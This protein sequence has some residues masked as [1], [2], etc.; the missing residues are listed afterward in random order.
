VPNDVSTP[1]ATGWNMKDCAA[2]HRRA[3]RASVMEWLFVWD[4]DVHHSMFSFDLPLL[5]VEG[6]ASGFSYASMAAWVLV[7]GSGSRRSLRKC[8]TGSDENHFVQNTISADAL[9]SKHKR[10]FD[11][12]VSIPLSRVSEWT[13]NEPETTQ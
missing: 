7:L 9:T 5:A 8:P 1:K 4:R 3:T 13:S 2:G 11:V 10:E 6:C 12:W